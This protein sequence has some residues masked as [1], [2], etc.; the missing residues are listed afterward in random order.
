MINFIVWLLV[1]ALIGWL[2][3]MV[4]RTDAQQGGLLNI[5]VGIVGAMLGGFLLPLLG[6]GGSNINNND[7]SVSGLLVAFVGAIILLAIVTL[8]QRGRVR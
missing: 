5:V 2:A 6:F 4:M 7:F 1:G 8:M 3:S